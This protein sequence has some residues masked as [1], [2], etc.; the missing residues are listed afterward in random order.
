MTSFSSAT[1]LVSFGEAYDGTARFAVSPAGTRCAY[2]TRTGGVD[3]LFVVPTNGGMPTHVTSNANFAPAIVSVVDPHMWS[4]TSVAFFAGTGAG[5]DLYSFDTTSTTLTNLTTTNGQSGAVPPIAASPAAQMSTR[6][7]FTV[8]GG[9]VFVYGGVGPTTHNDIARAGFSVLSVTNLTGS[10][11]GGPPGPASF[12]FP[13]ELCLA[14]A[15]DVLW[16]VTR[17]A[18]GSDEGVYAI[19]LGGGG[20]ATQVTAGTLPTFERYGELVPDPL[21]TRCLAVHTDSSSG[22]QEVVLAATTAA[23]LQVSNGATAADRVVSG[24]LGFLH[25]FA[26][27]P[28]AHY[29]QGTQSGGPSVFDARLLAVDFAT[30]QRTDVAGQPGTFFVFSAGN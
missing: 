24:S 15:T 19:D 6:G 8:A 25:P 22:D 27:C 18:A 2:V 7:Y 4:E 3:E 17:P 29:A 28:G 12:V 30:L 21:G 20:I 9:F 10:A 14:A 11:F 13:E 1:E 26:G 16:F 23:T 5:R